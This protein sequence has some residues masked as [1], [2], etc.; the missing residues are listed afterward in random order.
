MVEF[1]GVYPAMVTPLN[2]DLEIDENGLRYEVDFL[3]ESHVHGLVALGSSGEFPYLT[4]DEKKRVIDIVVEQTNGRVPVIVCTSSMGTD[5]VIQLSR[6]ARDRGADGLM[7]NLPIYFPLTDEDVFNHYEAIS[8][9]VD[10][11]ILLYDFPYVTHLEMSPELI[12]K[13]SYIEN[14][15]GIKETGTL[16]KVEQILRIEKQEPFYVFTGISFI[17]LEVLKIGGAGVICPIPCIVPGQVASI[18]ESFRKGDMEKASQLQGNILPFISIVAVPVQSPMVKE[19]MRQL[20]LNIQSY[21]KSPLPQITEAQKDTVRK[22]LVDQGM[23][24]SDG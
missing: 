3:I 17:L 4:V 12:S 7:I 24:E 15:V 14:V 1:K 6:Y 9:A 23:I 19:A 8:K 5:E 10:L 2:K 11:P 20:G 21:V 18:Y 22:S 16:E 13:L